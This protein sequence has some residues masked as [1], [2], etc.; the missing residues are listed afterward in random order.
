[1][2]RNLSQARCARKGHRLAWITAES[3]GTMLAHWNS[4]SLQPSDSPSG[5]RS[6]RK[7]VPTISQGV[8]YFESSGSADFEHVLATCGCRV[9]HV[10]SMT[11]LIARARS[12]EAAPII[13]R[14]VLVRPG[15]RPDT[16]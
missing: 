15:E 14:S 9:E 1:M 10:V 8:D 12:N 3:D 4:P 11:D 6:E 5:V 2:S 7:G 13:V 16:L